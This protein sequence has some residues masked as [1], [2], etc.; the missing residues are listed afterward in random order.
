MDMKLN[1]DDINVTIL[2]CVRYQSKPDLTKKPKSKIFILSYL[3]VKYSQNQ[4]FTQTL[5]KPSISN[6]QKWK[7]PEMLLELAGLLLFSDFSGIS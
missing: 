5:G 2:V 6:P 4:N 7:M 1:I 3:K